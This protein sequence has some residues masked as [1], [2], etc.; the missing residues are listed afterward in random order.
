MATKT[1]KRTA[2]TS[3]RG[4]VKTSSA[5][6]QSTTS[7]KSKTVAKAPAKVAVSAAVDA[8]VKKAAVSTGLKSDNSSDKLLDPN[9]DESVPVNKKEFVGR[10]AKRESLRPNQVRAVTLAVLEEL[11][12]ALA[13]GEEL[14]L[15]G[16]GKVQVKRKNDQG[17]A[18]VMICKVRRKKAG[19]V[20]NTPL[21]PAAE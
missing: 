20:D 7:S 12:L 11:G 6:P 13:N 19:N 16:L 1:K 2:G 3:T 10:V 18:E 8:A 21:A 17:A 4:R 9:K 15:P 5:K 14:K